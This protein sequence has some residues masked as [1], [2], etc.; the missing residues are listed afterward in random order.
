MLQ[1]L[2]VL[3]WAQEQGSEASMGSSEGGDSVSCVVIVT[4]SPDLCVIR[5][6]CPLITAWL[7]DAIF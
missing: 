3:L 7:W 6:Y 5:S 4:I 1:S 2:T